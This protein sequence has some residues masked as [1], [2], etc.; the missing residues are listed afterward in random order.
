[1]N[2]PVRPFVRSIAIVLVAM[3]SACGDSTP[4]PP[5]QPTPPP[6]PAPVT[7]ASIRATPAEI[8]FDGLGQSVPLS[9]T[10]VFSD[11]TTRDVTVEV[12]WEI[13]HPEIASIERAMLTG[14]ALGSTSFGAKY[15]GKGSWGWLTVDVPAELRV[16]V[17]GVVR[18]QYG[19]PVA[20]ASITSAVMVVGATTDASGAFE[21]DRWYGPL[22]LTISKFGY[23]TRAAALT[24]GGAP[25]NQTPAAN[26]GAAAT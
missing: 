26:A 25:A 22:P 5:T 4:A 9:V 21:L 11:G 18:D 16:P 8:R 10:A 19:R 12:A 7:L 15:Q 1:M 3:L 20:G 6:A 13:T 14:R 17:S 24:V 23:E 2:R